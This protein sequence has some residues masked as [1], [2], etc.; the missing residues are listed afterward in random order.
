MGLTDFCVLVLL[1]GGTGEKFVCLFGTSGAR[2][3]HTDVC[4]EVKHLCAD[5]QYNSVDVCCTSERYERPI[6]PYI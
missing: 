1:I 6:M 4:I 5:I 2:V 3:H